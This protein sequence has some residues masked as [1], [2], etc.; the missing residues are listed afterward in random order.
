MK[1]REE[2]VEQNLYYEK[3]LLEGENRF[4]EWAMLAYNARS[5]M[6]MAQEPS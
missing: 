6:T 5:K 1:R 4:K 3:L 2:E